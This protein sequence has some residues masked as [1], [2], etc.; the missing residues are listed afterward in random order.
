MY[1]QGDFKERYKPREYKETQEI[2][3]Y[4]KNGLWYCDL[5]DYDAQGGTEGERLMVS[6]SDNLIEGLANGEDRL[7]VTASLKPIRGEQGL[8]Y[9]VLLIKIADDVEE[10]QDAGGASYQ[11][12]VPGY[13][14]TQCWLCS[15]STFVFNGKHPDIIFIKK[16]N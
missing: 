16:K 8:D 3:F 11:A 1:T 6:N 15:V 9:D 7:E 12:I 5:E 10:H 13:G 4:K 14:I 2:G